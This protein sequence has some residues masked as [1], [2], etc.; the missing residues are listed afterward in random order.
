MSAIIRVNQLHGH[1]SGASS[2]KRIT[3][4]SR[5]LN[6]KKAI[7]TG[8]ASG[9]G[10][11]TAFLLADE[12]CRVA[13]L[14]LTTV[15]VSAVVDTIKGVHGPNAARGWACD[16]SDK[17]RVQQVVEE[18]AKEF[19][20]ID[21]LINN[22]GVSL[23]LGAFTEEEKFQTLWDKTLAINLTCHA[24]FI[25]AALPYLQKS[26]AGRIVNIASTEALLATAGNAAYNAS[27]AGVTGLTRSFAAELG[28]LGNITVNCICPGPINTGMT[29]G[30]PEA[31]KQTYARRRVPL[32][33]YGDPEEVAQITV[34]F[35]LPAASYLNG[36]TV[37]VDGGMSIRHT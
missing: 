16:V 2:E 36:V 28:R 23:N 32:R 18:V 19:G 22:A 30:L 15:G 20:G 21:I 29:A 17:A 9:M 26:E 24:W 33:R 27:K 34:S 12:G 6:G 31:S 8:A 35:C 13:A 4:L 25:R 1:I 3:K 14:D 10:R 7:V 37:P 11:A 5:S